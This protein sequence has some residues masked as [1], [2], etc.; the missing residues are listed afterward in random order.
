MPVVP[1]AD[2]VKLDAAPT[3]TGA[4]PES[5][6]KPEAVKIVPLG[7][8]VKL[9][10]PK[11]L[12]HQVGEALT[13]LPRDV[14]RTY[15]SSLEQA[16]RMPGADYE[17]GLPFWDRV[18]LSQ[19]D[20]DAERKAYL[21]N[22]FGKE[23]VFTDR[24]GTL[25]VR[26]G[27]KIISTSGGGT[28]SGMG[29]S[30]TGQTPQLVGIGL[31][32]VA[33]APF[34]PLGSVF[35][36][37]L[38]AAIANELVESQ[39]RAQGT[40]RKTP[41]ERMIKSTETFAGGAMGEGAG[42]L[43]ARGINRVMTGYLPRWFSGASPETER[44]TAYSLR[45]G[46]VPPI[47]S[48]LPSA[49]VTQFHQALGEKIGGN[50][51]DER[52]LA[53]VT[54]EM[55]RV[56]QVSGMSKADIPNAMNTIMNPSA[57]PSFEAAGRELGS[58]VENF[59]G[60]LQTLVD[61]TTKVANETLDKE[62]SRVRVLARAAR[63]PATPESGKLGE[64]I[65]TTIAAARH[66]FSRAAG[67]IYGQVDELVG[68]KPVVPTYLPKRFARKLLDRMPES[69]IKP[70]VKEIAEMPGNETFAN[71]QRIRTRLFELG[72]PADLAAKGMTKH[73]LR[74]LGKLVNASFD[75]A[76]LGNAPKAAKLL[77]SADAFYKQGI[78][79]FN[80][81]RINQLVANLR[82]GMHP[83]AS[84]IASMIFQRGF[85]DRA[86][87][88]MDMLPGPLQDQ[89]RGQYFNDLM[90]RATDETTKEVSGTRL[91]GVL[92][93]QGSILDTA[94]GK[95]TA[96][97]MRDFAAGL[98]A[99]D[100]KVP[101]DML[102]H[103]NIRASIH[104][105]QAAQEAMD[106]FLKGNYLSELANPTMAPEKVYSY[107][108]KPGNETDLEKAVHFFGANSPQVKKL[109]EAAL[110]DLMH[111]AVTNT[112]S[113]AARTIGPE[114]LDAA[115][116]RYTEKQQELLFPNGLNDDL[117]TVAS[118]ARFLFPKGGSDMAAGLAAGAIKAALPFG[119]IHGLA[120]GGFGAGESALG[121][122]A[123]ASVWNWILSRPS[124]VRYL[125]LGLKGGGQARQMSLSFMK[126]L[127]NAGTLGMLPDVGGGPEPESQQ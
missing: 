58:H 91:Y 4:A 47:R 111:R 105:A 114:A 25:L 34:G 44:M 18:S 53:A 81:A 98:R 10:R 83:D 31:G 122:Y 67:R 11:T 126:L 28:L 95:K 115:L 52:N 107:L 38:G 22:R 33:G 2:D 85:N 54:N 46:G 63:A 106:K 29:A 69:D 23:N 74:Q 116:S 7:A 60:S 77:K 8:D 62:L 102:K 24:N 87:Q 26:E 1:L 17:T 97:I 19:A 89:V 59:V 56:L 96:D 45:S 73:D 117:K 35:G 50:M 112:E 125:A 13:A 40:E 64:E 21:Q 20:N 76:F 94:F 61:T 120:T 119:A 108:V 51:L 127:V 32:S 37:G 9:D 6:P 75:R 68:D 82:T 101:V 57:A 15:E 123:W 5:A 30:L 66:D 103:G 80:D 48:A 65:A 72:E 90:G 14:E 42:E 100:E 84:K 113:G 39:K 70:I 49:K 55:E 16:G 79:K 12:H 78:Q 36:G 110:V 92:K 104:A 41:G 27:D 118:M 124:T 99:R 121:A 71:M 43:G 86:K 109:R 3:D 88:V 93:S